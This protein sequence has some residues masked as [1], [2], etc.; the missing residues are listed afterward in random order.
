MKRLLF[1]ICLLGFVGFSAQG[2]D[3]LEKELDATLSE[4]SQ[5]GG[6]LDSSKKQDSKLEDNIKK[7]KEFSPKEAGRSLFDRILKKAQDQLYKKLQENPFSKMSALETQKFIL[8]KTKGNILGDFL[9]K[10]PRIMYF[11]VRFIKDD[12]AIKKLANILKRQEDLKLYSYI[13][14]GNIIFFFLL[15]WYY[16]HK[17]KGGIIRAVLRKLFFFCLST[18]VSLMIFYM[19]FHQELKPTLHIVADAIMQ[20]V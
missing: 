17:S 1:F 20:P 12:M 7:E 10:S 5:V 8:D 13:L 9:E 14:I 3:D 16:D 4:M 15:G 11:I 6:L 19:L 2:Q 18:V